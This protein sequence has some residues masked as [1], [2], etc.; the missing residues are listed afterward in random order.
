MVR[1]PDVRSKF[2]P[3]SRR[4]AASF[5]TTLGR[6]KAKRCIVSPVRAHM[7][8]WVSNQ[9]RDR[10]CYLCGQILEN[11]FAEVHFRRPAMAS[12]FEHKGIRVFR[13]LAG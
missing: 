8:R 11:P 12:R 3:G 10:Q 7:I 4:N 2:W 9:D 5:A 1:V 13:I 6:V